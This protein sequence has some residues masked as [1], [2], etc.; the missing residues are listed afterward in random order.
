MSKEKTKQEP[1]Q[2]EEKLFRLEIILSQSIEEDFVKAFLEKDTG[3]MFTKLD[4]V[5]GQGCSVPK[6]GDSIWPQLNCM[7][8]TYCT[9]SQSS[10]IKAIIKSLR[11]EYPGEGIACFKT[12]AKIL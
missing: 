12:K 2:D 9:K 11:K 10:E 5:M 1:S 6:M 7:Y 3:H 4:N 8:I